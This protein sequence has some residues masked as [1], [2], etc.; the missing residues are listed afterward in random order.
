AQEVRPAVVNIKTE[1]LPRQTNNRS[2]HGHT[3]QPQN[4]DDNGGGEGGGEDQGPD[5]FQNFFNR[6]FGG[7]APGGPEDGEGGG[8]VQESLGSGFIVDPSGYIVTNDHVIDH[9][10]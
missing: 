7:Q 6:F 2:I 5:S 10:D 1:T 3:L 8:G 4:P 9:A